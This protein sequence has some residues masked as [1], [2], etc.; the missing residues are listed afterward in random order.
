MRNSLKRLS[1]SRIYGNTIA[2]EKGGPFYKNYNATSDS[3][4]EDDHSQEG[5]GLLSGEYTTGDPA[6]QPGG[7][8]NIL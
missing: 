1:I 7:A 6:S 5:G 4:A 8:A 3:T 2:N